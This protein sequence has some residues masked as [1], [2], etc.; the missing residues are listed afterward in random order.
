MANK[1]QAKTA[2]HI[3]S[4]LDS[5]NDFAVFDLD[6]IS[7]WEPDSDAGHP[8]RVCLE[9]IEQFIGESGP[10]RSPDDRC[11]RI[12]LECVANRLAGFLQEIE[13]GYNDGRI[14]A[15][16]NVSRCISS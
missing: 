4:L 1:I 8:Y 10:V 15:Y 5:W 14:H 11:R 3:L 12:M 16:D 2:Q 7:G 9:H 6:E 13:S